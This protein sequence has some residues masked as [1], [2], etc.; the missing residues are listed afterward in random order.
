MASINTKRKRK[1]PKNEE[2]PEWMVTFADMMTLLL[3]FFVLILSFSTTDVERYKSIAQ[4]MQSSFGLQDL[5]PLSI[6]PA[7]N[8]PKNE[9]IIEPLKPQP[10]TKAED[11]DS[12]SQLESIGNRLET[13]FTEEIEKGVIIVER[14]EDH[15]IIRFPDDSA[16]TSG[17]DYLE[18]GVVPVLQ[19]V[20]Q[21]ISEYQMFTIVGGHTDDQPINTERFRSNWDLSAARAVSVAH[22]L[23]WL[24][25]LEEQFLYVVGNADARPLVPNDSPANRIKNRRVEILLI[26]RPEK[27]E[28]D[29]YQGIQQAPMLR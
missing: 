11:A 16:F 3:T 26:E 24:T 12:E 17:S 2:V 5:N 22:E 8:P 21:L 25:D 6:I 23:T 9:N 7:D 15:I 27:T 4:A 20:G 29:V 19:K 18:P 28:R 14:D 10:S 13:N 1:A